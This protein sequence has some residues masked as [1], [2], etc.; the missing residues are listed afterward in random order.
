MITNLERDKL[1]KI[2]EDMNL[3]LDQI[4]T[5]EKKLKEDI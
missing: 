1:S 5:M 2:A 4:K 3:S